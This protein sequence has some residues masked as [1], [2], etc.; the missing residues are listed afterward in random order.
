LAADPQPTDAPWL[1]DRDGHPALAAGRC[2]ACGRSHLPARAACPWC[3]HTTVDPDPRTAGTVVAATTTILP[4]P[5]GEGPFHTVVLV[6]LGGGLSAAGRLRTDATDPS[7][8]AVGSPVTVAA[9]AL[10][11]GTVR[12]HCFEP[13]GAPDA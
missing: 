2:P 1:T 3:G 7:A 4:V 13:A 6:D 10:A 5:G 12:S 9:Q 11:D 8:V